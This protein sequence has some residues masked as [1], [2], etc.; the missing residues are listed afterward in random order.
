V[1][2][3]GQGLAAVLTTAAITTASTVLFD[4]LDVAYGYKTWEE[5]G[6]DIGKSFL[7]SAVTS[8]IGLGF[9]AVGTAWSG[10]SG[11]FGEIGK[12][13]VG[14]TLLAGAQTFTTNTATS[15][16]NAFN[17]TDGKLGWDTNSFMQGSFGTGAWASVAGA[18]GAAGTSTLLRGNLTGFSN[19]H[20]GDVSS[21]ANLAGGLASSGIEYG[22]SGQTTLNVLRLAGG[23]GDSAWGVGL[24]EMHL[25]GDQGF[26]MNFGTSGTD[27]SLGT[28][29]R[30]AEGM[31]TFV[32]QQEFNWYEAFGGVDYAAGYTESR[33]VGTQ[34]RENYSF[35]D[36]AALVQQARFLSGQDKLRVGYISD[37]GKTTAAGDSRLVDLATLG[38]KG[39]IASQ[40][41]AGIVMGHEAYRNGLYDGAVMQEYETQRAAVGHTEM[42]LRAAK[43][44]GTG[45][46]TSSENLTND[47]LNYLQ[48]PEEFAKYVGATY[49][50]SADYWKLVK[51]AK[52]KYGWEWDNSLDFD[53]SLLRKEGKLAKAMMEDPELAAAVIFGGGKISYKNMNGTVANQ[54]S[55][56]L[57]PQVAGKT[58]GGL[59]W[60]S[61]QMAAYNDARK[62]FEL[63]TVSFASASA[64]AQTLMA[65]PSPGGVGALNEA[66]MRVQSS[67]LLVKSSGS[68]DRSGLIGDGTDEVPYLPVRADAKGKVSLAGYAEYRFVD[69]EFYGG[70]KRSLVDKGKYSQAWLDEN[71][72]LHGYARNQHSGGDVVGSGDVIASVSGDYALSYDAK[73]GFGSAVT[74]ALMANTQ[75]FNGHMAA[76]SVMDY[77][78]AFSTQGTTLA[79]NGNAYNLNGIIAGTVIGAQG[80]TGIADGAHVHG[81]IRTLFRNQWVVA[82][83]LWN[84]TFGLND[85]YSPALEPT[86]WASRNSGYPSPNLSDPKLWNSLNADWEQ[87]GYDYMNMPRFF[88]DNLRRAPSGFKMN[89][90]DFAYALRSRGGVSW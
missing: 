32:K 16:L 70:L 59:E 15:A 24:M 81:E 1:V 6:L 80:S 73:Y 53:V 49:D 52:G 86:T 21:V 3:G 57:M 46:I 37:P 9:K 19:L 30:A 78:A 56:A 60:I 61:P 7:T 54:L 75:Y 41:A 5:A 83:R 72:P 64:A 55:Y 48:G 28:I 50:S 40:L 44:Y 67:G 88:V 85:V 76:E 42:A 12:G 11:T 8:T 79:K 62:A 77:M 25:G 89:W 10:A 23:S 47:V 20:A 45:L 43:E 33:E 39:N 51:D 38:Q 35:G 2:P 66:L 68:I 63:G 90:D 84:S 22:I 87:Y 29:R 18:A 13:V 69:D 82:P 4:S 31:G 17:W 65:N 36:Q 34:L 74:S 14:K 71:Y 27:M 58:T 26:G